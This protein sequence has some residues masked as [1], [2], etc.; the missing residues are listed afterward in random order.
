[1]RE[2]CRRLTQRVP[3]FLAVNNA[4][5]LFPELHFRKF[6]IIPAVA[7]DAVLRRRFAGE[8]IRLR[9]AGDGG[10]GGRDVRA[11]GAVP[12]LPPSGGAPGFLNYAMR[13]VCA[14]MSASVR[15]TTLMTAS[16]LIFRRGRAVPRWRRRW[17]AD[18]FRGPPR[19]DQSP[20]AA[21]PRVRRRDVRGIPRGRTT[22]S[23]GWRC[24]R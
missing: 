2:R 20:S 6:A 8:I 16:R 14:P 12:V 13:G 5:G 18:S 22:T 7:D 11:R 21:S 24:P 10:K 4:V 19:R 3:D 1:M 9:G 23:G 15:P 17:A